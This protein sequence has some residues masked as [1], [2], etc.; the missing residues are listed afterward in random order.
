MICKLEIKI[1]SIDFFGSQKLLRK[2]TNKDIYASICSECTPRH[3]T[4]QNQPLF[5]PR[6]L[7]LQLRLLTLKP[8]TMD[9]PESNT[10]CVGL[11]KDQAVGIRK[12]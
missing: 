9:V 12:V 1:Q 8:V 3:A 5:L 4:C 2:H 10:M 11:T 6:H 7:R